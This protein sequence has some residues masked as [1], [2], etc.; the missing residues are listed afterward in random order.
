[1]STARPL[2]RRTPTDWRHVECF[3]LR[4]L[5][6]AERPSAVPSAIGVN[7]YEDFDT[8]IRGDDGRWRVG[9][10]RDLGR[11]RGG[12]CV[13]LAP[14][15]IRDLRSWWRF[16]DQGEE[17]ACVG[18]GCSRMMSIL[19]RHRYDARWLYRCAQD[20]DGIAET[21][22]AEGTTV[23]AGG[24]VLR[25]LGHRRVRGWKLWEPATEE[26]IVAYRWA[27]DVEDLLD[28]LGWDRSVT[29]V[30]FLNSWGHDYPRLVYMPVETL[31]RLRQEDGEMMI[32]T[33]R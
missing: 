8:P 28:A 19:N 30:P 31:D 18:F 20:A 4:A 5:P 24:E 21:P 11:V 2:G 10:S 13:C 9:T 1:M 17:G 15:G 29:E 3:P 12:H 25:L 33:D 6:S 16:Y 22:P 32:V 27:T 7:W 14:V 26:G 23:R